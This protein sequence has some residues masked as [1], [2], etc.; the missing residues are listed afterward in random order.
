VVLVGAAAL[1][2]AATLHTAGRAAS[3]LGA[4]ILLTLV[5][6]VMTGPLVARPVILVLG[7]WFP[8]V[9]GSVGTLSQRNALRNPRRT[10]AT[11]SALMIGLAL[12]AA[13]SVVGSS[14][15][16]SFDQQV[17]RTI[18]SDLVVQNSTALPF[19]D[20]VATAVRAVPGVGLLVR[21]QAT[22]ITLVAPD[23]SQSKEILVG[24]T[25]GLDQALHL[26]LRSGTMAAGTAPGAIV[27]GSTY[28]DAHHLGVGSRVTALFPTGQSAALTVGAVNEVVNAQVGIADDPVIG[29]ATLER[30]V[31]GILDDGLFVNLAKGADEATVKAAVT[32]AVAKD[33]QVQVRD[34]ADYKTLV[35]GEINVL[36]NLIY[37]LLALAIIIAVL[38]VVNTLALSVVERT[39]EIGLLRAIGLSR[40][41]LRRMVRLESVVI[42]LFGAVVGLGLGLVWG[43]TAQ[44]LL[45]L[46]G[47]TGLSVPW[48]TV[49][50]VVVGAA[51]VG[52]LAALGPALR[53]S[54]LNVL[55]AIAHE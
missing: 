18:G 6:L 16:A 20:E 2:G 30:Y 27:L 47:M 35:R 31:P 46:K 10:S 43:L 36:L 3:L 4:G 49:L 21:T 12:V 32:A 39:R 24:T 54:R 8:R 14:M 48:T 17:D 45:A 52:L 15:A 40:R 28:A 33:P 1:V 26:T 7:G 38:G 37:G 13:L 9:F 41:Q 53:A 19:P 42:S 22:R 23:G 11:A 29:T 51:L 44:R 25:P 50:S 55:D 5:G 34:L